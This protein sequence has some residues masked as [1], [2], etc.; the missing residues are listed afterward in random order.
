M[1][2]VKIKK[3]WKF[4]FN[5]RPQDFLVVFSDGIKGKL[6]ISRIVEEINVNVERNITDIERRELLIEI[7]NK[8]CINKKRF[9][10]EYYE[11]DGYMPGNRRLFRKKYPCDR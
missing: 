9:K 4:N 10:L 11:Y 7:F 5:V 1:N 2:N 6:V 8:I 3:Y